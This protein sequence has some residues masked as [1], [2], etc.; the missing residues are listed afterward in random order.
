MGVAYNPKILGS[1]KELKQQHKR[2]DLN[3]FIFGLDSVS[4]MT[5]IRKLPKSRNYFL[6]ILKGIELE[7]YNIVGDGTIRFLAPMLTGH[8][9]EELGDMRKGFKDATTFDEKPFIWKDFKQAGY[10]T[11]WADDL[12]GLDIVELMKYLESSGHLNETLLIFMSDHGAR[13]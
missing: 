11:L 6:N 3:V 10:V 4:R 8:L 5:S 9:L 1:L 2:I 7:N 12:P 13:L